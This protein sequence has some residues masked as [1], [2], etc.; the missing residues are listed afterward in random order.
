MITTS[1]FHCLPDNGRRRL[2]RAGALPQQEAVMTNE[3]YETNRAKW[4]SEA[5]ELRNRL[6]T[7]RAEAEKMRFALANY[8]ES[9]DRLAI[10][11]EML[12][13]IGLVDEIAA[14]GER[15]DMRMSPPTAKILRAMKLLDKADQLFA[16]AQHS[17]GEYDDYDAL[18]SSMAD[19]QREL[20]KKA[21]ELLRESLRQ[22]TPVS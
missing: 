22:E 18:E 15:L 4:L 13:L 14:A 5:Q 11:L 20:R 10:D 21:A 3:Q 16:D 9:P 8:G 19:L 2:L 12:P 7:W 1:T 6:C 17:L